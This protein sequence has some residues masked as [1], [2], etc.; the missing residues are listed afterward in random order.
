MA[1]FNV[2]TFYKA[3]GTKQV[4]YGYTP[5]DALDH[6]GYNLD[7]VA[8]N[9]RDYRQGFDDSLVFIGGKWHENTPEKRNKP[10]IDIP[11][12]SYNQN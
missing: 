10:T 4:L 1:K 6:A 3:D 2:Y 7:Y 5:Q 11:I 12:Y 8:E 9:I